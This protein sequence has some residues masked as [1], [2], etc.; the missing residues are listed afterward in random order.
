MAINITEFKYEISKKQENLI[1]YFL[2]NKF[3]LYYSTATK[4]YTNF[5]HAFLSRNKNED[6]NF[7][8]INSNYWKEAYSL[9]KEICAKHGIEHRVIYRASLNVTQFNKNKIGDFHVD[10]AFPHKNFI[11]YLNDFSNGSTYIQDED[12]KE[13]KEIKAEKFKVVI[14]GG[15]MHAQGFCNNGERRVVLVFTFN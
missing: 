9:F 8:V 7:G 11:M 2:S 3:P 5:G 4:E 12:T 13:L 10:H 6:D 1:D 15:Q 14:F